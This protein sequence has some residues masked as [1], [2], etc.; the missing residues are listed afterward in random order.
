[1]AL[2]RAV[3]DKLSFLS[4]KFVQKDIGGKTWKFFAFRTPML[5][6]LLSLSKPIARAVAT[7]LSGERG[8]RGVKSK[9]VTTDDRR[10]GLAQT[11][12]DTETPAMTLEHMTARRTERD[13]AIDE[14]VGV[15]TAD[16][17]NLLGRVIVDSL[18]EDFP[19]RTSD[20]DVAEFWSSLDLATATQMLAGVMEANADVIRPFLGK[21]GLNLREEALARIK[22]AAAER[23]ATVLPL[24]TAAA[25]DE[26]PNQP[27]PSPT[28][29]PTFESLAADPSGSAEP[30]VEA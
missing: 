4:P 19:G 3:L 26:T 21:A 30:S 7:L 28:T 5:H 11:V 23:L 6:E 9:T 14:L 16:G 1:M 29:G 18:R 13:S 2:S 15:V 12:T 17:R 8:L 25:K 10:S 24:T 22:Q 27:T 20:E